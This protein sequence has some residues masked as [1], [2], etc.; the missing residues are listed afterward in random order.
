MQP[1]GIDVHALGFLLAKRRWLLRR[2]QRDM[3]AQHLKLHIPKRLIPESDYV[4]NLNIRVPREGLNLWTEIHRQLLE[5][6]QYQTFLY[7][8]KQLEKSVQRH[9]LQ[10]RIDFQKGLIPIP[11]AIADGLEISNP[12]DAPLGSKQA[13]SRDEFSAF[14]AQ[15]A[16]SSPT[17]MIDLILL[18]RYLFNKHMWGTIYSYVAMV[19]FEQLQEQLFP[20]H[21]R[22]TFQGRIS[23]RNLADLLLKLADT[24]NA[25]L[26]QAAQMIYQNQF[27]EQPEQLSLLTK[28]VFQT[29]RH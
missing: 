6:R 26:R 27:H 22:F 16:F 5:K 18:A 11:E 1:P 8:R 15:L 10:H 23:R 28:Q 9:E 13:R 29:W 7:F 25:K 19:V 24:P 3:H 14:V 2:W 12:L 17:A 20:E 4:A 21:V